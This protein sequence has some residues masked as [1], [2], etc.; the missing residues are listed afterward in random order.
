MNNILEDSKQGKI[1]TINGTK[2][3][4]RVEFSSVEKVER[5]QDY[6]GIKLAVLVIKLNDDY[7]YTAEDVMKWHQL[8][9]SYVGEKIK[10]YVKN[11]INGQESFYWDWNKNPLKDH[12]KDL[13]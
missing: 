1:L 12:A 7:T 11:C 13:S 3:Y 8:K 10:D 2:Y 6:L 9:G 5:T 4:I